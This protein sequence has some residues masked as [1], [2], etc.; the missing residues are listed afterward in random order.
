[1][2]D[3][4]G[5]RQQ[6]VLHVRLGT[7]SRLGGHAHSVKTSFLTVRNATQQLAQ[8]ADWDFIMTPLP[9]LH[10]KCV[11]LAAL[12]VSILQFA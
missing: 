7:I 9:L 8:C 1:M 3:V 11:P 6:T 12:L 10:A 4:K 2:W 5:D